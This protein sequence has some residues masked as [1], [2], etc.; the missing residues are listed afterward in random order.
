MLRNCRQL[1][2]AAVYVKL[3]EG[4]HF[5]KD[6]DGVVDDR[7][8]EGGSCTFAKMHAKIKVG[9]NAQMLHEKGMASGL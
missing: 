1:C 9:R 3:F 4:G 2:V 7:E 5:R 6:A 8:K